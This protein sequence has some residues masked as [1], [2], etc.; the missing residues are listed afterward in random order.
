MFILL[1][2]LCTYWCMEVFSFCELVWR[3]KHCRKKKNIGSF[4]LVYY[5]M[6]I[7]ARYRGCRLS[8]IRAP[9]ILCLRRNY[10]SSHGETWTDQRR[11][12]H[13]YL[14]IAHTNTHIAAYLLPN[15]KYFTGLLFFYSCL[16]FLFFFC[17]RGKKTIKQ[18]TKMLISV[19]YT[20]MIIMIE[21]KINM[22]HTHIISWQ[23]SSMMS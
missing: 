14:V 19:S 18:K 6:R 12:S 11:H 23:K 2:P 7:D 10:P 5:E 21:I 9:R 4:I 15:N 17:C 20:L 16:M 22:T 13:T 8:Y 3:E 1:S